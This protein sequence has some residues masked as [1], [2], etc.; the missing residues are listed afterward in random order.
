MILSKQEAKFGKFKNPIGCEGKLIAR[1]KY[2]RIQ[3]IPHWIGPN[4][5]VQ[6]QVV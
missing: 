5:E 6:I 4:F 1:R 2:F 3:G